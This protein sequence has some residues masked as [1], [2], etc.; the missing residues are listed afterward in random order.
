MRFKIAVVVAFLASFAEAQIGPIIPPSS[1]G[2]GGGDALTSNPLSQFAATTCAQFAGVITAETGTCGSVVLSTAPTFGGTVTFGTISANTGI[3][4]L[5]HASNA[6]YTQFTNSATQDADAAYILP[7]NDGAANA[8]LKTDGSGLLSWA[9]PSSTLTAGSAT[10]G[11]TIN[12]LVYNDASGNVA[13]GGAPAPTWAGTA[14][15]G[16]GFDAG[17][18]TTDVQAES[19]VQ[20]WNN[21]GIVFTAY[22]YVAINTASSSS[23]LLAGWYGG[24]AGTTLAMTLGRAGTLTTAGNIIPGALQSRFWNTSDNS[25]TALENVTATGFTKVTPL[26]LTASTMTASITAQ[27]KTTTHA[28]AWTNAMV[29]TLGAALTGD[30]N[31]VTLPAKTQI[32]NAYLVIDTAAGGV[33]TLTVSCGD[34]IGGTPFINYIVA[35]DAKAAANTVYG[36]AVAE[37]GTSI[38]VEFYYLP[39]YT[40]TTLV[41][42]HFISTVQNLDQTTTSTGRLILT[43]T[44]LP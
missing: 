36:D 39:S 41:T 23:S 17:T 38:D 28:Y 6:F 11:G 5:F 16:L 21:A 34:A 15:K 13:F 32:D 44:L 14:G 9:T 3:L 8:F 19:G 10:S 37:R 1:G 43:T 27:L 42:C 26:T 31:V 12:S 40:A 24:A 4:K 2:A 30:I 18:A 7:V 33:T 35:S 25:L 29:V 20:T 22:K